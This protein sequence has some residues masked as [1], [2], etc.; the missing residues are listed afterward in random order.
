MFPSNLECGVHFVNMCRAPYLPIFIN[1]PPD[2]AIM[3]FSFKVTVK[4][5]KHLLFGCYLSC[6]K[7]RGSN[8]CD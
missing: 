8:L 5:L 2:D 3:I 1:T 7:K 4:Y 6:H